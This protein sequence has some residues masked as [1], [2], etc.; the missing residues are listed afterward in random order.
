MFL[1]LLC[2]DTHSRVFQ[3][4]LF[5]Q[6]PLTPKILNILQGWD[7]YLQ[8]SLT[9]ATEVCDV[10]PSTHGL[11]ARQERWEVYGSEANHPLQICRKTGWWGSVGSS[12]WS[13]RG[14]T[15]LLN[16]LLCAKF[17]KPVSVVGPA[18]SALG[19]CSKKRTKN[20]KTWFWRQTEIKCNVLVINQKSHN[21]TQL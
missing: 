8:L 16:Y 12:V 3:R 19:V 20:W 2:L 15:M 9:L 4:I 1:S 14:S 21:T 5:G 7:G 11:E 10:V 18:K 17:W 6:L 13:T